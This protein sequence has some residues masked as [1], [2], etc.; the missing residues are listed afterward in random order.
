M[1]FASHILVFIGIS[2]ISATDIAHLGLRGVIAGVAA[3]QTSSASVANSDDASSKNVY[4][5]PLEPC[6]EGGMAKTGFYRDGKC[7]DGEEDAG[8]HHILHRSV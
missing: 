7:V 8:S 4:G 2:T 6:S 3:E 1:K 5:D